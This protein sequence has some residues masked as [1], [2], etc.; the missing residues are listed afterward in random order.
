MLEAIQEKDQEVRSKTNNIIA[1]LV[2]APVFTA[3]ATNPVG[4]AVIAGLGGLGTISAVNDYKNA[5]NDQDK[6]DAFVD[7]V[8]SAAAIGSA[9]KPIVNTISD[10]DKLLKSIYY[11]KVIGRRHPS[12]ATNLSN[13]GVV[14]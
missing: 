14:D 6:H 5:N 10:A 9:R 13:D 4:Q 1:G 3:A 8:I 12:F 11:S 7:G 2:S